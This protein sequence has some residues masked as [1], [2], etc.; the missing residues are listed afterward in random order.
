MDCRER[1]QSY[2]FLGLN[3]GRVAVILSTSFNRKKLDIDRV[4]NYLNAIVFIVCVFV[5]LSYNLQILWFLVFRYF[6]MYVLNGEKYILLL[7]W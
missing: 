7:R 5:Y 1:L 4:G 6:L 3:V 2:N